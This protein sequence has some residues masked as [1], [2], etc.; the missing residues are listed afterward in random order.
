M[1]LTLFA[2]ICYCGWLRLRVSGYLVALSWCCD[3]GCC[4]FG[5]SVCLFLVVWLVL[6]LIL[7]FDCVVVGVV[8]WC[9]LLSC[10]LLTDD[11]LACCVRLLSVV[12]CLF[13]GLFWFGSLGLFMVFVY[14][15]FGMFR[16]LFVLILVCWLFVCAVLLLGCGCVI[17]ICLCSGYLLF[18]VCLFCLCVFADCVVRFVLFASSAVCLLVLFACVFVF[19]SVDFVGK[20]LLHIYLF[21]I[22]CIVLLVMLFLDCF[23][24]IVVF[25]L[26]VCGACACLWFV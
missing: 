2:L 7:V 3:T 5:C 21:I 15:L 18:V 4:L 17:M 14:C 13:V 16:C 10:C 6:M 25:I 8:C 24:F 9:S 12:I 1:L 26:F 19:N 23:V 22:F 20:D 11:C